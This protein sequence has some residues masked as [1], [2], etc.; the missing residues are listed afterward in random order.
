MIG[1]FQ[2]RLSRAPRKKLQYFPKNWEK[3]FILAKKLKY[4][5]I[6]FFTEEKINKNNPIWSKLGILKY[7]NKCKE[8]NLKIICHCDNFIIANFFNEKKTIKYLSKLLKKLNILGVKNLTL[9]FYG[10]SYMN[11]K[12]YILF[13]KNLEYLIKDNKSNLNIL[14]E[15][16]ISPEV[17]INIK[18]KLKTKKLK[19]LFDTGNRVNLNRN[20]YKDLI[21]LNKHIGHVH[22]KDKNNKNINVPIGKGLVNFQRVFNA[23]KKINYKKDFTFE[24]PREENPLETAKK[25]KLFFEKLFNC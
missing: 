21:I 22:L 20:I 10:K 4:N 6:E 18:R 1:I 25:N 8:N 19:F 23:L 3:E 7:K 15:S 5:F 11:D 17:F 12:N 13:L 9:P 2:G 14:I 16:D 24:T